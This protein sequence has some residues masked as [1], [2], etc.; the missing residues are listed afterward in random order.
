MNNEDGY[1]RSSLFRS[2]PVFDTRNL[3]LQLEDSLPAQDNKLE[4]RVLA[5]L[6]N[7]PDLS[8]TDRIFNILDADEFYRSV[9]SVIYRKMKEMR[10]KGVGI[11]AAT[12]PLQFSLSEWEEVGG[13]DYIEDMLALKPETLN[14]EVYADAVK[15]NAARRKQEEVYLKALRDVR[16][17]GKPALDVLAETIKSLTRIESVAA[18]KDGPEFDELEGMSLPKMA[19]EAFRGLVGDIVGCILPQTEACKEAI[20]SQFIV[21]AGNIVGNAP[22]MMV[23]PTKHRCNLYQLV[24]GPTGCG[25]GMAFDA[26]EY[27]IRR[28]NA[29]WVAKPFLSGMTSGEGV[30]IEAKELAGPVLAVETEFA[31]TINNMGREH[32]SL[33]AILR[34]GFESETMRIPTKNNPV[35]VS[36]V[37]LSIIAHAPISE[38]RGRAI[39]LATDDGFVNRFLWTPAYMH[40][41]LPEGG[42]FES[43]QQALA[44]YLTRLAD[45]IDFGQKL[46]HPYKRDAK[47]QAM[48]REVYRQLRVRRPGPHGSATARAAAITL[49]LSMIYAF[50]DMKHEIQIGHLRSALAFWDCCDQMAMVLFGDGATDKKMDKLMTALEQTAGGLDRTAIHK[51]F[52]GRLK[53]EEL[54]GLLESAQGS[55]QVVY[56]N[57]CT[58]PP[59]W[60]HRKYENSANSAN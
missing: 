57:G 36:G 51:L 31:R 6:M 60:M 14:G 15:Q 17:K 9:H 41:L 19:D 7:D 32:N 43:I 50:L 16:A 23:G 37:H 59:V 5:T 8:V 29:D 46:K 11:D 58:N 4:Q 38:I 53:K 25:K 10:S 2:V 12:L 55:G 48:W 22:R 27:A 39:P 56:K 13:D 21:M 28:A 34:Q 45:A 49:R 24:V 42:D 44:P 1:G 20:L 30:I 18:L 26:V 47:A 33:N 35:T 54:K 52:G 40:Q 3:E